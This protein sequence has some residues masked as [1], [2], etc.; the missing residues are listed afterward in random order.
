MDSRKYQYKEIEDIEKALSDPAVN[1][2]DRYNYLIKLAE[3]VPTLAEFLKNQLESS[4]PLLKPYSE[5]HERTIKE[6]TKIIEQQG[7]QSKQDIAEEKEKILLEAVRYD[8][9]RFIGNLIIA[10]ANV[11]AA[12]EKNCTVLHHAVL[13]DCPSVVSIL[14]QAGANPLTANDVEDI[15]FEVSSNLGHSKTTKILLDDAVEKKYLDKLICER[16]ANNLN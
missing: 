5:E 7:N 8:I 9:P 2:K 3:K 4:P 10:G 6:L 13:H 14:L 11:N 1:D 15:P 16:A 12:D